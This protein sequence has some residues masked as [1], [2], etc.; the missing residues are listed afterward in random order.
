[1]ETTR[2]A[3]WDKIG[4]DVRECQNNLD[5][6]LSKAGLDYSVEYRPVNV[7]G[8]DGSNDKWQAVVRSSDNY[9]YNIA[10]KS[11]TICQNKDAFSIIEP[12]KDS[13]NVVKA[14]ETPSGMIYLIAEMP[15][16]KILN[17]SFKPYLIFQNSHNADFALKTA[18]VPL[19]IVCQNQFS[20][21][22]RESNNTQTIKHTSTINN[23]ISVAKNILIN[24]AEYMNVF[25]SHAESL[26]V[27]KINADNVINS[28]FVMPENATNRVAENIEKNKSNFIAI[29]N[30]DDNANFRGTAWGIINAATDYYTH[31]PVKDASQNNH[32]VNSILYPEFVNRALQLVAA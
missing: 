22:F 32:F 5:D 25:K 10:K 26:A 17:D 28:L 29:Y 12:L 20:V 16:S 3:T 18:I 14:G 24:T 7:Q 30:N 1:M 2:L 23:Q 8:I 31:K 15:E 9:V 13:I 11:Y 21:S 6:I 4:T 19:R 27:K